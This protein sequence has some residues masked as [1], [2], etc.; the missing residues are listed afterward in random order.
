LPE[1]WG[2]KGVR[3]TKGAA[4]ALKSRICLYE[5]T[6][7]K[8][9]EQGKYEKEETIKE[10]SERLSRMSPQSQ[11]ENMMKMSQSMNEIKK[12]QPISGWMMI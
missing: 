5:G 11:L 1:D 4:L 6:Y 7:R 10:L 3:V 12:L 9:H 8:Y 2:N